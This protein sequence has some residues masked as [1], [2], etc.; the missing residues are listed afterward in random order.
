LEQKNYNLLFIVIFFVA[1]ALR[2]YT[3][4]SY[5]ITA[6]ELSALQR[7]NYS[8]FVEMIRNGVLIDFHPP[9]VQT[10]MYFWSMIFGTTEFA[11]RLPF[12]TLSILSIYLYFQIAQKWFN[13]NVALLATAAITCNQLMLIYSRLARPYAFGVFFTAAATLY[14]TKIIVDKNYSFKTVAQYVFYSWCAMNTHYFALV[15]I[16]V[17]GLGSLFFITKDNAKILLI[18]GALMLVLFMPTVLILKHQLEAGGIGADS[19]GWLW[20]P[21]F[22]FAIDYI[23][24]LFNGSRYVL[25]FYALLVAFFI[26]QKSKSNIDSTP[27]IHQTKFRILSLVFWLFPIVFGYIYSYT[28]NPILQHSVLSFST[29]FLFIALFSFVPEVVSKKVISISIYGILIF[30]F[31]VTVFANNFY[32]TNYFGVYKPIA[33]RTLEWETKY[34][35]Q[36]IT[37]AINTDN[38][39]FIDYYFKQWN[40]KVDYIIYNIV[41]RESLKKVIEIVENS[42]TEYFSFAWTNIENALEITEIIKEKFPYLIERKF[43]FNSEYYLFC[44]TKV[45]N[46]I[47]DL[48]YSYATNFDSG[49]SLFMGNEQTIVSGIGV[50]GSNCIALSSTSEYSPN[51]EATAKNIFVSENQILNI[52]AKVKKLD[53][54]AKAELVAWFTINDSTTSWQAMNTEFFTKD[55]SNWYTVFYSLR[56]PKTSSLSNKLHINFWNTSKKNILFDDINIYMSDGNPIIYSINENF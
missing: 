38:P 47:I 13:K 1:A 9:L 35:K 12:A 27:K 40:K 3:L 6:D 16:A 23:K 2:F 46:P 20:L 42:N 55:T 5:G 33:M 48:G 54:G 37:H 19:G 14:F 29:P 51:F 39:F 31:S 45:A 50:G 4:G 24:Y 21:D 36:N 34:G 32:N 8:S 7:T 30:V 43:F 17:L 18:S 44:K 25:Y 10:F 28:K 15:F 52:K 53:V 56:L 26:F 41:G 11:A 22:N 49:N